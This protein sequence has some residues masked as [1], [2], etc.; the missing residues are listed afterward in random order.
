MF[1]W[2]GTPS[3]RAKGTETA[4]YNEFLIWKQEIADF[5]ELKTWQGDLSSDLQIS[6]HL[7]KLDEYDYTEGVPEEDELHELV[8]EAFAA[9]QQR[10]EVCG[11]G[12]PFELNANGNVLQPRFGDA[13]P[14]QVVYKYLLLATRLNMATDK[15]HADLD[16]TVLFEELCA[17]VAM[18]YFGDNSRSFVFGTANGMANF[19]DKVNQLC[20]C[21]GEGQQFRNLENREPTAKDDGL[22][23]AVW[24]P[25]S[26]GKQGKLIGFGQCKTGT[27]Y[28]DAFPRLQPDVFCKNWFEV[29]P[30]V[31]PIRMFFVAEALLHEG[32]YHKSSLAGILLDRCRIIEFCGNISG[33]LVEKL[34][35]WTNTAARDTGIISQ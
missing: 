10:A 25:F 6:N 23:I 14:Q 30:A 31:N 12:Y 28:D 9:V 8:G 16:G 29:M 32:W 33:A 21:L 27:N 35:T 22:D 24:N 26:D 34:A 20:N 13:N 17:D 4:D 5:S 7:S 2:P 1:N 11:D 19:P 3:P 18:N 15:K